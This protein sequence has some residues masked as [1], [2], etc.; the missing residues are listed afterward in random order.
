METFIESFVREGDGCWRCI[1]P[2]ELQVTAGR[3]Q[4]AP[5]TTFTKGTKFMG[6]DL[7]A[8]LEEHHRRHGARA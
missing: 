5:G 2:A 7:A 6:F 8:L 1:K 4:V 3:I